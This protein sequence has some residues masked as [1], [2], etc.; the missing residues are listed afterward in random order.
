MGKTQTAMIAGFTAAERDYIRSELDMFFSTLPSVA[1][2]FQLRTWRGGPHAGKPKIPQAAQGLLD[3]GLMRL[4][5]DGRLP[6]LFFTDAGLPAVASHAR[7]EHTMHGGQF[8][9]AHAQRKHPA[10]RLARAE[11][12]HPAPDLAEWHEDIQPDR[13]QRDLAQLHG[14]C[15]RSHRNPPPRPPRQSAGTEHDLDL[16]AVTRREQATLGDRH[17]CRQVHQQP[18]HKLCASTT[19]SCHR[20]TGMARPVP[21]RSHNASDRRVQNAVHRRR[22]V[23]PC[24]EGL[25]LRLY[26]CSR[27]SPVMNPLKADGTGDDLHRA[28]GIVPPAADLDGKKAGTAGGKQ[29]RLPGEEPFSGK[30]GCAVERDLD[31]RWA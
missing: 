7:A 6:M 2:G 26:P 9:V 28:M 13:C 16:S 25:H 14:C 23:E 27:R 31:I 5:L 29:S 30:T 21:A 1:E 3:R 4:D 10:L 8:F 22:L 17:H 15:A 11:V 18:G 19:Q 20:S 12:H 24:Q